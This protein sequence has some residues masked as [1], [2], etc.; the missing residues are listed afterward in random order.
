MTGEI[1]AMSVGVSPAATR[2]LASGVVSIDHKTMD[3]KLCHPWTDRNKEPILEV[4]R[5][6][7]PARGTVL[8]V[9]SGSGQH[10]VFFAEHLPKVQWLPS[11]VSA[12]NLTSI[13]EW[14][15][16]RNLPNLLEP[17]FLDVLEREWKTG[18]IEAVFNANMIH[19]TPWEC[20][21]GLLAGARRHVVEEGLL[22][23]YGPFRIDDQH[24]ADS[25]AQFDTSLRERDP[26]WGIRDLEAVCEAAEGFE[27]VERAEMP[28]NNQTL[29]FRRLGPGQGPDEMRWGQ[30]QREGRALIPGS[31]N[32]FK[33]SIV[34]MTKVTINRMQLA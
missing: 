23:L 20:C 5:R 34:H 19:I 3:E 31:L 32:K 10:A 27:L 2:P 6:F 9:G 18:A 24:T 16:E 7:L 29:V 22:I 25:N 15:G 17:L 33:I 30:I 21:L 4:L 13:R 26:R 1:I 11:D 14:A 12:E 28:A 8:E